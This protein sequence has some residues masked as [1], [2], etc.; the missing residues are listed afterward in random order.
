MISG[1]CT[2]R[3]NRTDQKR[4]YS[5]KFPLNIERDSKKIATDRKKPAVNSYAPIYS[6]TVENIAA[7]AALRVISMAVVI[8][9]FA[10][11]LHGGEDKQYQTADLLNAMSAMREQNEF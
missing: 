2:P 8:F 11:A 1:N 4:S 3:S 6:Q 10:T 7:Y 9:L 5:K